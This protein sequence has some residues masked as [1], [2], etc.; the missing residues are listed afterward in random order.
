M[1]WKV[2][3]KHKNGVDR[4]EIVGI[5]PDPHFPADVIKTSRGPIGKKVLDRIEKKKEVFSPPPV[6]PIF[7]SNDMYLYEFLLADVVDS[8]PD[9]EIES[10]L[11]DIQIPK[12][13][14]GVLIRY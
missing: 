9:W 13:K 5:G 6:I 3:L 10:N 12:V 7:S 14:N 8:D 1:E 11:P 2:V 4:V